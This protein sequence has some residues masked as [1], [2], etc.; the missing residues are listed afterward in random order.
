MPGV[1]NAA[2]WVLA[3]LLLGWPNKHDLLSSPAYCHA[4]CQV[5]DMLPHRTPTLS[6]P[7]YCCP[8]GRQ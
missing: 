3:R 7:A 6:S 8:A 4:K 2:V 1:G 5:L